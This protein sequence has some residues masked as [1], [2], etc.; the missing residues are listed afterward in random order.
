[1]QN[2]GATHFSCAWVLKDADR[3]GNFTNWR[4]RRSR[5][6][7]SNVGFGPGVLGHKDKGG[8]PVTAG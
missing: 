4:G 7:S 8:A 1:M 2:H 6:N 5:G 3:P